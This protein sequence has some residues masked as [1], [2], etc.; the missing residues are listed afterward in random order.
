MKSAKLLL[1]GKSW[2]TY[3][4]HQKGFNAFTEGTYAEGAT[5][6][7]KALKESGIDVHYMKAH[8]VTRQFPQTLGE[9]DA[10]GAVLLSD[11]GSDS[12]LLHPDTFSHSK[13]TPDRLELLYVTF[14]L[15]SNT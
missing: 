15:R 2:V 14:Q 3:S 8:E 10:Y 9:I 13:P 7:V 1:A 6:L 4:I 11:I 12:L 5:S